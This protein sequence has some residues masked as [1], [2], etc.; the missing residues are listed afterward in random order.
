MDCGLLKGSLEQLASAQFVNDRFYALHK[1]GA[2]IRLK[3]CSMGLGRNTTF[4]SEN[5][6]SIVASHK[7]FAPIIALTGRVMPGDAERC[8]EAGAN[9]YLSKPYPLKSLIEIIRELTSRPLQ[10]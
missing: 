9:R 1:T 2:V 10:T 8:F 7:R 6:S 5:I 4:I 3:C